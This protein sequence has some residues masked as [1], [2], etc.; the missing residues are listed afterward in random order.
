M[1]SE[2]QLVQ[3]PSTSPAPVA[4]SLPESGNEPQPALQSLLKPFAS[5]TYYTGFVLVVSSGGAFLLYDLLREGSTL[6]SLMVML[7]Y[8]V[9]L[10]FSYLLVSG[11]YF[12]AR[13]PSYSKRRPTRWL[14]LILWLISAYALNRELPVFQES[15]G[16]FGGA[17]F[18]VNSSMIGYAWKETMPVRV[19][20]LLYA[21]L[22]VG[23]VLFVYMA[24]YVGELYPISFPLLVGLGL[25]VHTFVPLAF[26]ITL[27]KRIWQDAKLEEHLRLGVGVGLL[28]PFVAVTIFLTG[29]VS[30]L[31]TLEDIRMKALVQKTSDMPE[32]VLI[33]QQVTPNWFTRQFLLAGQ[34]SSQK[35][36]NQGG[37][38][39]G[40]GT[41][42]TGWDDNQLHDPLS[43]I[44]T[45]FFPSHALSNADY[46]KVLNVW[47][48]NR[49]M[50]ERKFWSGA[51]LTTKR[52]VS[53]V[54]IW[55]QFRLSYTEKTLYI[56][57]KSSATTEEALYTFYLP[58]GSA[59]SSMSLWVNGREEP[60]RLTTAARADSAYHQIVNVESRQ[61]SRDPSI[62][63]WREGNRITLRVF[64]CP[65]HA[66]RRV[67]LGISSPLTL[68]NG[69]LLYQN[70]R[71]DGPSATSAN[72]LIHVEFTQA[73]NTVVPSLNL[74]RQ[75][76]KVLTHEGSYTP[77]WTIRMA[78]PA[79]SAK[80]FVL[81]NKAYRVEPYQE[82][83]QFFQP[84]DIYL[85][86]NA[87]WKLDELK[88]V[89]REAY[90]RC[91]NRVWVFEDGLT[92][93]TEADLD[94]TYHRLAR[95]QFSLFPLYLIRQPA[96]ALLITKGTKASPTLSDL[97]GSA[98]ATRMQQTA[99]Q[100]TPIRTFCLGS[101][102]SPYLRTLAELRVVMVR[103]GSTTDLINHVVNAHPFPR[104]PDQTDF[105]PLAE[106]GMAIRQVQKPTPAVLDDT[107]P[108]HLARLFM[109]NH[110]LQRIGRHYFDQN[111]QTDS[112]IHE[113]QQ[114]HV[115]SPL[116]SFA[117]LESSA[118][119]DRFGIVKDNSG[120]DNATLKQEGAVPEPHEW[121]LL[122]MVALLIGW[123]V[124]KK[125]HATA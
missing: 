53:Q 35:S 67:K 8:G 123:T 42:R 58:P 105:V 80:S 116:S 2:N 73:P 51:N 93:L 102:V 69:Q 36:D 11:G 26:S 1:K 12:K 94:A 122:V 88:T 57:N 84:A 104:R 100:I 30:H 31:H 109:Y 29:W 16:W 107:A 81:D 5:T 48:D 14:C 110:L 114:A 72:E 18:L 75:T 124:W 71:F 82:A 47:Q 120:L 38:L 106:A 45:H 9:A 25:S 98:F 43:I 37:G 56:V 118:D 96:T 15:V 74:D 99:D 4:T 19:Q 66:E 52:V 64:P 13:H 87:A 6:N 55:P 115:V 59:I 3:H 62:V 85:D 70:P 63:S 28:I 117:V 21:V 50:T 86:L 89:F 20:Q 111:Y 27:I 125:R 44:A 10:S 91:P 119:Y 61:S 41:E 113:A 34:R 76:G 77:D 83:I 32:W 65:A 101:L 79:L 103:Q 24:L 78:A 7:H 112:L 33:A 90:R 23:A 46:L 92:Q 17:L 40:L 121:A 108:D 60:A 54:R 97:T 22:T 68:T 39:F 49:H 95:Q